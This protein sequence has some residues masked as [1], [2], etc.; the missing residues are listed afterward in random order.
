MT[1]SSTNLDERRPL[2]RS[3]PGGGCIISAPSA[4]TRDVSEGRTSRTPRV[5]V[6]GCGK[7]CNRVS[8]TGV[9]QA[10]ED[11]GMAQDEYAADVQRVLGGDVSSFEGIVRRWQGPLVNLAYRYCR[12]RGQAEDMAQEAFLSAYR[13]LHQW[14]GDAAFSSWLFA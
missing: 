6:S 11:T 5:S 10:C 7:K 12:D 1:V 13:A 14:R 4:P 3:R 9:L 8:L 2:G